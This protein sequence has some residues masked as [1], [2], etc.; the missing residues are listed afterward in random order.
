ML[1]TILL[2]VAMVPGDVAPEKAG[3]AAADFQKLEFLLGRWKGVGPD[4]KTF[5][6]EY[7]KPSA[8]KIRSDRY[9]DKT[10]VGST[11]SSEVSLE[12]GKIWSRW[13]EFT[14]NAS[15]VEAGKVCFE[16]VNAPS[17][18]CWQKASETVVEVTQRWKDAAGAEQSYTLQLERLAP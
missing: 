6:E 3:Y 4:G 13:G 16:P 10:F 11:D 9:P 17:S 7:T 12:S 8:D 15:A 14:W 5:F 2:A 1:A 18:F